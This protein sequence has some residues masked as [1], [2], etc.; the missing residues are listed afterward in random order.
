[1]GNYTI[2]T[3]KAKVMS[4]HPGKEGLRAIRDFCMGSG[5]DNKVRAIDSG[6]TKERTF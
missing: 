2:Q 6:T 1:M 4:V 3:E 5:T